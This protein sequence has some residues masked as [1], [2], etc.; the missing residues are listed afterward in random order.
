MRRSYHVRVL[1]S[2]TKR[3]VR[4]GIRTVCGNVRLS[5]SSKIGSFVPSAAISSKFHGYWI[6]S[7]AAGNSP[8]KREHRKFQRSTKW[9]YALFRGS[10]AQFNGRIISSGEEVMTNIRFAVVAM[11]TFFERNALVIVGIAAFALMALFGVP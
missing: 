5:P 7:S 6:T 10:I 1:Q 3:S 9:Q 8:S 11:A 4:S 2:H